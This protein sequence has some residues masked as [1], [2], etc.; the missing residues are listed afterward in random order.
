M[1]K[2][3]ANIFIFLL[4]SLAIHFVFVFFIFNKKDKALISEAQPS[5]VML[6]LESISRPEKTMKRAAAQP[7]NKP[8]ED[9]PDKKTPIA[10]QKPLRT[11]NKRELPI[12]EPK[13]SEPKIPDRTSTPI[14]TPALTP[15]ASQK[16]NPQQATPNTA[17]A[18][19]SHSDQN[20]P[21]D[22][23]KSRISRS[24]GS[25]ESQPEKTKPMASTTQVKPRR[26]VQCLS[27]PK[28]RYPKQALRRGIEGEP[29]IL[30]TINSR[31][32][33]Q[34]VQLERSSGNPDI[35]RAAMDAGRRSRFQA[36]AGGA[37]VPVSY[38]VVIKGSERHQQAIQRKEKQ[39]YTLP[40]ETD[41]QSQSA[42]TDAD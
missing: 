20:Q 6:E 17:A 18:A 26:V 5:V 24:T 41:N 27:C 36:I 35:D 11:E 34:G 7:R 42:T 22:Q 38:S 13:I 25:E 10:Q 30:I 14:P 32:R 15:T 29:R 8:P 4:I 28:P 31:G 3:E 23:S 2:I 39:G 1:K 19:E 33:V 37:R 9:E 21:L 12:S 16:L 40:T